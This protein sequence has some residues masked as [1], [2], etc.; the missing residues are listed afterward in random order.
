MG[1][2]QTAPEIIIKESKSNASNEW[3]SFI[4]SCLM[5]QGMKPYLL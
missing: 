3:K 2:E 5:K 1:R 4:I